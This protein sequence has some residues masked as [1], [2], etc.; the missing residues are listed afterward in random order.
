MVR[1]EK[2]RFKDGNGNAVL[3]LQVSTVAELPDLGSTIGFNEKLGAGSIA[4]IIQTGDFVTLDA[5][6]TWYPEQSDSSSNSLNASLSAPKT[7]A[8]LGEGKSVLV[9]DEP[10]IDLDGDG[11]EREEIPVKEQKKSFVESVEE[12][13]QDGDDDERKLL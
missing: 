8:Q 2:E 3:D 12:P 11:F 7:S 5:N 6:G 4:Q 1:I 10:E 13:E 9:Q